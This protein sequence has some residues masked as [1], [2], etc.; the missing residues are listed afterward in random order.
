MEPNNYLI[1][2]IKM[3]EHLL[4]KSELK[5]FVNELHMYSGKRNEKNG[6]VAIIQKSYYLNHQIPNC[7]SRLRIHNPSSLTISLLPISLSS[8]FSPSRIVIDDGIFNVQ[9]FYGQ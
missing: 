9:C 6:F 5:E 2:D 1:K 3:P 8:H 7:L 4:S